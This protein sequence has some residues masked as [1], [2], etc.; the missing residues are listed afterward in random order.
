VQLLQWLAL[1]NMSHLQI[2][3]FSLKQKSRKFA[4]SSISSSK[5]GNVSKAVIII[6]VNRTKSFKVISRV[7]N[8]NIIM[9]SR[10][11]KMEMNLIGL[12]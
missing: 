5:V 9:V 7:L 2:M 11:T 10:A 8:K 1:L 12:M 6:T 3:S 4:L